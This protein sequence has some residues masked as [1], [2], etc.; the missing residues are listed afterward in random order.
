MSDDDQ[1][2]GEEYN[3]Y[4]LSD[5][6]WAKLDAKSNAA[7]MDMFYT[8]AR[9]KI[10]E[11]GDGML[12]TKQALDI[13]CKDDK[14]KEKLLDEVIDDFKKSSSDPGLAMI[15]ENLRGP[16]EKKREDAMRALQLMIE[17]MER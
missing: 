4:V 11:R 9:K 10:R 2:Y 1:K 7:I 3:Q 8:R 12:T 13:I 15:A 16:D 14:E 17:E 6:I 5:G